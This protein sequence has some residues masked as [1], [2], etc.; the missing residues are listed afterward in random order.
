MSSFDAATTIT[1]LALVAP[2]LA[3]LTP[4]CVVFEQEA[5]AAAAPAEAADEEEEKPAAKPKVRCGVHCTAAASRKSQ[6]QHVA[7]LCRDWR[8]SPPAP[9]FLSSLVT[10]DTTSLALFLSLA[11][12]CGSF[13]RARH[14][15]C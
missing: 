13:D 10:V 5:P 3:R 11:F 12:A 6:D 1:V 2:V 4:S 9:R 14:A 15:V 7:L 8:L